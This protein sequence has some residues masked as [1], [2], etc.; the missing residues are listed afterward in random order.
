MDQ[1]GLCSKATFYRYIEKMK[2]KGMIDFMK[3]DDIEV[4]VKVN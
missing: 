3:I 1:E 2:K 4:V